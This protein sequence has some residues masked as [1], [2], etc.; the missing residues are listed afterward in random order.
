MRKTMS[1]ETTAD[2]FE[3]YLA[4][5]REDGTSA[6]VVVQLLTELR[7]R[8]V[9]KYGLP[10]ERVDREMERVIERILRPRP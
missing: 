8:L 5:C 6:Y 3:A 9:K 2:L 4:Q 1:K 7:C 10:P